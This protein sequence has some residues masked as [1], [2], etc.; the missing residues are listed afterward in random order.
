MPAAVRERPAWR[1]LACHLAE[2]RGTHLRDLFASDPARGER[3]AA[4]GAG[5]YLD[6]SKNRVTDETLRLLVELAGRILAE[7]TTE[8]EPELAHDSST[9]ALVRRYRELR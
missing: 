9:N 3:M 6:Y 7:L 5:L 4:E 8:A 2:A 1:A